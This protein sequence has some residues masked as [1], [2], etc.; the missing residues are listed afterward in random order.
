M[1]VMLC[2]HCCSAFPD[3]ENIPVDP[4]NTSEMRHAE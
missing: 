2:C 1:D 4:N 3:E